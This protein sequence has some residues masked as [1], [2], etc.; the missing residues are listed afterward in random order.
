VLGLQPGPCN[1]AACKFGQQCLQ[2]A[3]EYLQKHAAALACW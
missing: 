3:V 1:L 2:A